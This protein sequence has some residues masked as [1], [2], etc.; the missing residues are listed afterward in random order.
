[1]VKWMT[2]KVLHHLKDFVYKLSRS[3][4]VLNRS[5][6]PMGIHELFTNL[7]T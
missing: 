1:M 4:G 7:H 5:M 3:K 6:D 2:E